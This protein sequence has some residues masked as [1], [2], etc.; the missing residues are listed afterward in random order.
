MDFEFF[1]SEFSL[2]RDSFDLSEL[3]IP[4]QKTVVFCRNNVIKELILPNELK[5]IRCDDNKIQKLIIPNS[6]KQIWCRNN[7]ITDLNLLEF[8]TECLC[9][10]LKT[11]QFSKCKNLDL[12]MSI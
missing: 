10:L 6:L 1:L 2:D 12:V 3:I 5:T 8:C 11:V 9:D 7:L 4:E